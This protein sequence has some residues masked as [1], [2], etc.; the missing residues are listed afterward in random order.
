MYFQIFAQH[1]KMSIMDI[2]QAKSINI[3]IFLFDDSIE[4]IMWTPVMRICGNIA[5]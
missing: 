3:S 2:R 4:A 1:F 5:L